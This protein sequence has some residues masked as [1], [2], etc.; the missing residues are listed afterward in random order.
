MATMH[1]NSI[2]QITSR[3]GKEKFLSVVGDAN[4]RRDNPSDRA[5]GIGLTQEGAI[6]FRFPPVVSQSHEYVV[7]LT[8]RELERAIALLH[9]RR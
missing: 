2:V 4:F 9:G 3:G 1:T 6:A 5:L 8:A 7:T